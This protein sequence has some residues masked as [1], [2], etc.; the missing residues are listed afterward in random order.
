[1]FIIYVNDKV[2]MILFL[3]ITAAHLLE[4]TKKII[5]FIIEAANRSRQAVV[6]KIEKTRAGR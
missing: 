6:I 4:E 5:G 2:I 1:M 3:E